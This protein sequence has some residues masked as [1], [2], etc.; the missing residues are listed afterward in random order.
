MNK[1]KN[2]KDVPSRTPW[3][4]GDFDPHLRNRFLGRAKELGKT[5][6]TL[7]AEVITTY[8]RLPKPEAAK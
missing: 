8:L 4:L 7:L 1:K 2:T 3:Q 6:P 5:G